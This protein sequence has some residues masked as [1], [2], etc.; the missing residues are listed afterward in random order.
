MLVFLG[1]LPLIPASL[2][3]AGASILTGAT[4]Q[5]GGPSYVVGG[6]GATLDPVS[7]KLLLKNLPPSL[8]P[9]ASTFYFSPQQE[10]IQLQQAALMQTGKQ[11]SSMV[12]QQTAHR[13]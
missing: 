10:A 6:L 3:G 9:S 2:G 1:V 7:P 5:Q 11:A 13:S 8:Q 4:G 12:C